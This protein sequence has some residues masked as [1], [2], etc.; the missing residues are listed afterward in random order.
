MLLVTAVHVCC[1]TAR[2]FLK[3]YSHSI[4]FTLFSGRRAQTAAACKCRQVTAFTASIGLE[5][6][7]VI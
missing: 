2:D 4:D 5:L 6:N 1:E 3:R 7:N